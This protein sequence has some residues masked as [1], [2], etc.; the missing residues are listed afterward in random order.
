MAI[1]EFQSVSKFYK[2]DFWSKKNAAVKNLSFTVEQNQIVG[3]VGP[4]GAGKTTSIKMLMG[5]VRTSQGAIFI[6]GQNA[7]APS[8]RTAIAYLSEQPYFYEHLT[9]IESLKFLYRLKKLPVAAERKEIDRVLGIVDLTDSNTRKMKE[10]SKGMQQRLNMAQA[11]LGDGGIFVMDEPM[12]GMDPPGRSLFRKIFRNL[13]D[14]GKSIF[15]STHILDDIEALCDNVVV[16]NKGE[17]KY[18]GPISTVLEKGY[19]GIEFQA[20]GLSH[21]AMTSLKGSGLTYFEPLPNTIRIS[22]TTQDEIN[23]AYAWMH[24]HK[25]RCDSVRKKTKSLESILYQ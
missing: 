19:E 13:I 12:S 25:V 17:L 7:K 9:V 4:N 14:Q 20:A 6:N 2:K 24:E 8:A 15:F 23:T 3:F 5:L 21:A 11:L 18:A 10:L 22:A 1:L 16:L